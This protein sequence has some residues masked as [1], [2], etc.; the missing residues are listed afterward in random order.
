MK[1]DYEF[2]EISEGDDMGLGNYDVM[3][4]FD[5]IWKSNKNYRSTYFFC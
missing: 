1:N 4:I 2:A 5:I 3:V